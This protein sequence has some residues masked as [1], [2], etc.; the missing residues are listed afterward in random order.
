ME[1]VS[2]FISFGHRHHFHASDL[3][4]HKSGKFLD[5]QKGVGEGGGGT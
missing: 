5:A 4:Q 1:N 2:G 3:D